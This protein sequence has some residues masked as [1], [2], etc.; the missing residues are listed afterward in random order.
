MVGVTVVITAL[1][2]DQGQHKIYD[3]ID[4][5][6]LQLYSEEL[7]GLMIAYENNGG[8]FVLIKISNKAVTRYGINTQLL[9]TASVGIRI[10]RGKVLPEHRK[11]SNKV[12]NETQWSE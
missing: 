1:G 10:A 2:Q 5:S 6:T 12:H 9:A 8:Y 3:K 7:F 11:S 4:V